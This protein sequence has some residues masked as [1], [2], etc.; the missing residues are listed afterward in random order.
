M[1]LEWNEKQSDYCYP[2]CMKCDANVLQTKNRNSIT[3]FVVLDVK[4]SFQGLIVF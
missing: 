4:F 2:Q 1:T 3:L